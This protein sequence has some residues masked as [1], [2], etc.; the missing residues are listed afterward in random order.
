MHPQIGPAN[1]QPQQT[2]PAPSPFDFDSFMRSGSGG[3]TTTLLSTIREA[4]AHLPPGPIIVYRRA[5]GAV[6][7]NYLHIDIFCI[8]NIFSIFL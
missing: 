6:R 8:L 1:L 5:G 7:L 4:D 2:G 3:N